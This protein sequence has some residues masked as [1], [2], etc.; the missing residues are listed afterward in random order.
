MGLMDDVKKAQEMA[1]QAQQQAGG[2]AA[3]DMP[4]AADMEYAQTAQKIATSGLPGVATIKSIGETGKVDAGVNKQYAI[5]VAIELE[6]GD[7]YDTTV[8]QNLTDDAIGS[9]H[10]EA[11]K[12]FE[13][14][15]DP[16]DKSKALLYGLAD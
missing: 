2:A 8:L 12:K 14:K 9:G 15:V 13:V 5:E 11:G 6:A 1:Q 3:A 4:D 7:K 10:Y 16:D